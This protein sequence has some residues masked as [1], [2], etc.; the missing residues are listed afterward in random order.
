MVRGSYRNGN[1]LP[2]GFDGLM[3]ELNSIIEYGEDNLPKFDVDSKREIRDMERVFGKHNSC[4]LELKC[5]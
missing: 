1:F 5:I 4:V 2:P 3:L